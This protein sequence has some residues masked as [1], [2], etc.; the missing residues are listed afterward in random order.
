MEKILNKAIQYGIY[1]LAFLV[2]LFFLPISY[3]P[4]LASKQVFAT[5]LISLILIFWI[6]K[7]IITGEIKLRWSRLSTIIFIFLGLTGI[8]TLFSV[9]R[10][11]SFFG[12]RFASDTFFSFILYTAVFFIFSS[13]TKDKSEILR[14][15]KIFV[16]SCSVLAVLFL[17]GLFVKAPLPLSLVGTPQAL[18]IL[19]G[20]GLILNIVLIGEYLKNKKKNNKL[21]FIIQAIVGVLLLSSIVV[22]NFV[23]TW[24]LLGLISLIILWLKGFNKQAI[25]PICLLIISLFSVVLKVPVNKVPAETTLSYGAS[26]NIAKQS[27][28]QS[29]DKFMIGTGPGTFGYNYE[30]F[31]PKTINT[32]DFWQTRFNQSIAVSLTI[33]STTGVLGFICLIFL[34]F[35]FLYSFFKSILKKQKKSAKKDFPELKPIVFIGSLYFLAIWFFYSINFTLMFLTFLM[36][37]LWELL[38]VRKETKF[39]F[40]KM[41]PQ[42]SFFTTISFIILFIFIVA[43]VYSVFLDYI[44][45]IYFNNGI[46]LLRNQDSSLDEAIKNINKAVK[47]SKND[48]YYR[49]LSRAYMMKLVNSGDITLFGEEKTEFLQ[50]IVDNM[51]KSATRAFEVSPKDS[52]NW[53]NIADIYF[54]LS[55]DIGVVPAESFAILAYDKAKQLAPYS[56]ALFYKSALAN[57]LIAENM[58]ERFSTQKAQNTEL[59]NEANRQ[60]KQM[61]L[62]ATDDLE[63]ALALRPDFAEAQQLSEHISTTYKVQ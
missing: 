2:P 42:R 25:I 58:I 46:G 7:T 48:I 22:I 23:M 45:S 52:I 39:Q 17:L 35:Y 10:S 29:V 21:T 18:G 55:T 62:V 24:V 30:L 6:I 43:G 38:G 8:S 1:I 31:K 36:L 37:G 14:I 47:L 13:L 50:D 12:S 11:Q 63:K 54:V 56:P 28:S 44:A 9:S 51:E 32:T 19:L 16:V 61:I 41:K 20:G 34:V 5:I 3:L 53:V 15:I 60:F 33:L 4:V 27:V 26:F 59:F 40:K 57:V 49:E